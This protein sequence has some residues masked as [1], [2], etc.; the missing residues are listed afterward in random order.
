MSEKT[1]SADTYRFRSNKFLPHIIIIILIITLWLLALSAC[2]PGE[3]S[4][5]KVDS[6][7]GGGEVEEETLYGEDL[8]LFDY[9][10][11]ALEKTGSIGIEIK[12]CNIYTDIYEDLII[13]GEIENIST[14]NKTDIEVTL[15]FYNKD[16]EVIM[17]ETI[18][19]PVN[20]LNV[21]SRLPF[22]Y[23]L[24]EREKF[25]EINKIKIGADYKDYNRGFKGNPVV[26]GEKYY[27]SGEG[28]SLVIEGSIINIGEN[29]IKNLE[30]FC[31]FYNDKEQVVFI[32]NCYL[33]REEMIPGEEQRFTL[34]VMLD[35][36]LPGF[37]HYRF[38]VFFEDE[39]KA[40]ALF[41]TSP[42]I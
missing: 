40:A 41:I 5:R 31:T 33:L 11:I 22:Y 19:S 32:K 9:E 24:Y 20:Y 36:Y 28:N 4:D 3:D 21:G 14:V 27:Y 12:N 10:K 38:E 30:L 23:Y 2:G 1:T 18:P 39:I 17:S 16:N 37:T 25:I 15:D 34:E 35:E 13:L 29:K 6:A 42:Y 26:E 8:Y 7:E